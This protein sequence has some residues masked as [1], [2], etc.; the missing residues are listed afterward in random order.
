MPAVQKRQI[1]EAIIDAVYESGSSTVLVSPALKQPLKFILALPN[2]RSASLWV[3]AWTLTF[4]GRPSLPDEYR[5]QMTSV[6][7]PLELAPEG[8]TLLIGYEPSLRAF[9]GFDIRKH[10]SFSP[11]SPSIQ[12]NINTIRRALDDGLA[13]DRKTNDEI[14]IGFRK[15]HFV[16]YALNALDLHRYGRDAVTLQALNKAASLVQLTEADLSALTVERRRIIQTVGRLSRSSNFRDQVLRAY[17]HRCAV[18]RLQLKLVDA[19][20]ILPVGAPGSADHVAN[21]IA[22]SPTYHRAYDSGLIYLDEQFRMRV[23]PKRESLLANL[24]LDA[25]LDLFKSTL[26]RIH[27]PPDRNQWPDISFIRKANRVRQ[28]PN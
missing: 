27:L 28:I 15:D 2:E 26:G 4:G 20:H 10:R 13:F 6:A 8:V 11:G 22:L 5:I 14:V 12:I 21:G 1:T 18:T 7:P 24:N 23:N 9:A 19:A 16:Q 3:Y 17:D 25:G